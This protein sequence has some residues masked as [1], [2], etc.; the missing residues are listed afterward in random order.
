MLL[1]SLIAPS[2]TQVSLASDFVETQDL[3]ADVTPAKLRVS[4]S[5]PNEREM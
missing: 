3:T 5:V 2:V 1:R 4:S